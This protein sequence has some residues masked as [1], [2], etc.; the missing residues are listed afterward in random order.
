MYMY[1]KE[2]HGLLC[3]YVMLTT[4][5][6]PES[7][8]FILDDRYPVAPSMIKELLRVSTKQM[9]A[10]I[11]PHTRAVTASSLVLSEAD[12]AFL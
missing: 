6:M 4:I 3:I 5:L 7:G 2:Q 9:A 10:L 12:L 8:Q 1:I 11:P